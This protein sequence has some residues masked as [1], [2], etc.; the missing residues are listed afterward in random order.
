MNFKKLIASLVTGCT[1]A[2][3][4]ASPF[5]S[6]TVEPE[7]ASIN[8]AEAAEVSAIYGNVNNDQ[9]V[10]VFDLTLIRREVLI[11]GSTSIDTVAADVN[12]DGSVDNFDVA[13]VRDF[14]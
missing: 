1:L 3:S 4:V 2:G 6:I 8:M 7:V 12:A 11:P 5:C 10:D 14:I 9:S 13:E